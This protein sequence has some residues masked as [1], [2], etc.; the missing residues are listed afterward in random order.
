MITIGTFPDYS[1]LYFKEMVMKALDKQGQWANCKYLYF[2]FIVGMAIVRA[3]SEEQ[4]AG[5]SYFNI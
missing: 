1:C 4:G 5:I 2:I 3:W